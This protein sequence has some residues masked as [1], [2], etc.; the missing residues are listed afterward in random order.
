MSSE[1]YMSLT[2]TDKQMSL[3]GNVSSMLLLY[4]NLWLWKLLD[5]P[6]SI[7]VVDS[8]VIL[9]IMWTW[10]I[11]SFW[12]PLLTIW[13]GQVVKLCLHSWLT[14]FDVNPNCITMYALWLVIMA[15][16]IIWRVRGRKHSLLLLWAT[17]RRIS[18]LL[19]MDLPSG[20]MLSLI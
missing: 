14:Y 2:I 11:W 15:S 20:Q 12:Y 7:S 8:L 3:S 5:L 13:L 18:F 17:I 4:I 9:Y 6:Q 19:Q 10:L 16:V 1:S